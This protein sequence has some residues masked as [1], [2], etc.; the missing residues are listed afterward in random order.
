MVRNR[1]TRIVIGVIVVLV[2]AIVA[3]A[4][5]LPA[6]VSTDAIRVRLAQDLSAWTGYNVQLREAPRLN[7]FPYP[8]ASLS[9]VTLTSMTDDSVPLMEAER[10]EVDLSLI[11]A[12]LGRISFSQTRIIHPRFVMEEPVKTVSDFFGTLS[13]SQG[14]FGSAVREAREIVAKNPNNPDTTR[15]LSQPFGRIVIENGELIYRETLDSNSEK[16]TDLNAV[17]E[18]PETTRAAYFH[19]NARWHGQLTELNIDAAQAL[20][21]LSGGQSQ[22]KASFNSRRGGI[23]FEGKGRLSDNFFFDGHLA[24][25]SPGWNQTVNWI[26]YNQ[27]L[28]QGVK[29]PL[30]W[31]SHL[32][33]QSGHVQLNDVFLKLGNDN[34]RGALEVNVQNGQPVTTGSLA[35][36]GLDLDTLISAV[37]PDED[38]NEKLDLTVLDKIDLDLRVSAPEATFG[39]VTLNN[40]AAAIQIRNGHGIFD[41]GNANAFGGS[42]QCNIQINRIDGNA[43]LEGRISGSNVDVKTLAKFLDKPSIIEAKTGFILLMHAPFSRWSELAAKMDGQLT[44]NIQSGRLKGYSID[45]LRSMLGNKDAFVLS[46][47]ENAKTSFDRW[48]IQAS[49]KNRNL[50]I[51]KSVMHMGN[52]VL[53]TKGS[54][55]LQTEATDIKDYTIALQSVLE[56]TPRSDGNCGDV[57]CLRNSLQKPHSFSMNGTDFPK[58]NINIKQYPL[59]IEQ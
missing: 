53:S 10:I 14:T 8:R 7:L 32:Q 31:E 51:N 16:I 34:A 59:D 5:A 23:T 4:L 58:G 41:L 42:I 18:W 35:F 30:V 45:N 57:T 40:L 3:I 11:D 19:S 50:D 27:F 12:L 33:A 36:D 49:I 39:S 54:A 20:L 1:A 2:L 17:M 38:R 26:G 29:V 15:L 47:S 55:K 24:A 48:D 43:Y 44:L 22:I 25:R 46:N 13:R 21:F 28:G 9:G 56:K 37:F 52:W 6:L